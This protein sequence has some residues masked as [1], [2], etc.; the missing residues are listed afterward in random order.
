MKKL[1]FD[2]DDE[3]KDSLLGEHRDR[4]STLNSSCTYFNPYLKYTLPSGMLRCSVQG[5]NGFVS[6]DFMYYFNPYRIYQ[7]KILCKTCV[8]IFAH[9]L[10]INLYICIFIFKAYTD[11]KFDAGKVQA[12]ESIMKLSKT[13]KNALVGERQRFLCYFSE[14]FLANGIVWRVEYNNGSSVFLDSS[15]NENIFYISKFFII[16]NFSAFL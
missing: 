14:L 13:S 4:I 5:V 2:Q 10:L 8:P 15:C 11:D 6:R 1:T 9:F 16:L 3:T 12:S 7:G